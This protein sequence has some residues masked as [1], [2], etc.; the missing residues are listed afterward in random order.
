MTNRVVITADAGNNKRVKVDILDGDGH[1]TGVPVNLNPGASYDVYVHDNARI[2]VTETDI[3]PAQG[4]E[5]FDNA[6][7]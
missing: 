3:D 4:T 2:L 1:T 5:G 6:A 7:G